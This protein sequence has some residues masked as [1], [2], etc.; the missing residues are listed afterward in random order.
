MIDIHTGSKLVVIR[1]YRTNGTG[2]N[3]SGYF[4]FGFGTTAYTKSG[5][6]ETARG[7]VVLTNSTNYANGS[8]TTQT[9]IDT[10]YVSN[11]YRMELDLSECTVTGSYYIHLRGGWSGT[12]DYGKI[13]EVYFE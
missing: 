2:D 8:I 6:N 4:I 10:D 7:S 9:V 5:T 12:S 3:V 13:Y 1:E 11:V